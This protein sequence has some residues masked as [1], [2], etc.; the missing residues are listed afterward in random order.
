[1]L[2]DPTWGAPPDAFHGPYRL[3]GG[4]TTARSPRQSLVF[5]LSSPGGHISAQPWSHDGQ[6]VDESDHP[7]QSDILVVDHEAQNSNGGAESTAG[8]AVLRQSRDGTSE[9]GGVPVPAL[10]P[11]P[12]PGRPWTAGGPGRPTSAAGGWQSMHV[13]GFTRKGLSCSLEQCHEK[14]SILTRHVSTGALNIVVFCTAAYVFAEPTS[15]NA[16]SH[17]GACV[18]HPAA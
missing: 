15:S 4:G 6:D 17:T 2:G 14:R 11:H 3:N 13:L 7:Q 12:P 16:V 9:G 8:Y 5:T 10:S 18:I 1:M